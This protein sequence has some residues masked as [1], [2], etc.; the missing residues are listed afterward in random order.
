MI[1]YK[2]EHKY[3]INLGKCVG[4]FKLHY[5][6]NLDNNTKTIPCRL[7]VE[8]GNNVYDTGFIGDNSYDKELNDLGFTNVNSNQEIGYISVNKDQ[9]EPVIADVTLYTP[10]EESLSK[11]WLEC[12]ICIDAQEYPIIYGTNFLNE[13]G[14]NFG[15]LIFDNAGVPLPNTWVDMNTYSYITF[16]PHD[17][18]R[19]IENLWVLKGMGYYNSPFYYSYSLF[20]NWYFYG[21][22]IPGHVRGEL[23][24]GKINKTDC[25]PA[26]PPPLTIEETMISKLD[27]SSPNLSSVSSLVSNND[28][29]GAL[30]EWKKIT[31]NRLRTIKFGYFGPRPNHIDI[32]NPLWQAVAEFLV[33]RISAETYNQPNGLFLDIYGIAGDPDSDSDINWTAKLIDSAYENNEVNRIRSSY[34]QMYSLIVP[35]IY[36][37]WA[38]NDEIYGKKFRNILVDFCSNQKKLMEAMPYS[39]RVNYYGYNASWVPPYGGFPLWQADRIE[40]IIKSL[41]VFAKK[42]EY[43]PPIDSGPGSLTT[44]WLNVLNSVDSTSD[45]LSFDLISYEDF[46]FIC[47]SLTQDHIIGVYNAYLNQGIFNQRVTGIGSLTL[48]LCLFPEVSFIPSSLKNDLESTFPNLLNNSIFNDGGFIESSFNYNVVTAIKLEDVFNTI[49]TSL[50]SF[51]QLAKNILENK[52]LLNTRMMESLRTPFLDLPIVGNNEPNPPTNIW[53]NETIRNNWFNL[54]NPNLNIYVYNPPRNIGVKNFTSIAFPYSGYYVQR[55]NWEWDSPYLFFI[56]SRPINAG[57]REMANSLSLELHAYGRQLLINGGPPPYSEIYVREDQ[58]SD[59]AK[60]NAYFDEKSTY[61]TNT[62]IVNDL[63][64]S[65]YLSSVPSSVYSTTIQSKWHNSDEFDYMEGNYTYGYGPFRGSANPTLYVDHT[66]KIIFLKNLDCW[67][68]VDVLKTPANLPNTS[69]ISRDYS[70]IWKFPP[71]GQGESGV[72]PFGYGFSEGQV[73]SNSGGVYTSDPSGPNLSIYQFSNIKNFSYTKYYG[74]KNLSTGSA[75]RGWAARYLGDAIPAVDMYANW[76][77]SGDFIIA[78]LLIPTQ[79]NSVPNFTIVRGDIANGNIPNDFRY[80]APIPPTLP[81]PPNGFPAIL[82][83]CEFID[84][85][86][87]FDGTGAGINFRFIYTGSNY[88]WVDNYAGASIAYDESDNLWKISIQNII[89]YYSTQLYGQWYTYAGGLVPGLSEGDLSN[90]TV[91]TASCRSQTKLSFKIIY[92]SKTIEFSS[93]VSKEEHTC[94]GISGECEMLLTIEQSTG[95]TGMAL[96]STLLRINQNEISGTNGDI[97]FNFTSNNIEKTKD[98]SNPSS[99][100]W[101]EDS[102]GIKPNYS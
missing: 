74:E 3:T 32:A 80:Y 5:N 23:S 55:K 25:T 67:I 90:G 27:L 96:N 42:Q 46:I 89:T 6:F 81:T 87:S 75:Y 33:G 37:Y 77:G 8:W 29:S 22:N 98:I 62:I 28:Y 38:E 76:S 39:E 92:N 11:T 102:D 86:T 94:G 83:A 72:G 53:A 58:R 45:P 48:I 60:I 19:G 84:L 61:K 34:G 31:F 91:S 44:P 78:S 16:E 51:N 70:Q 17:I 59:F 54:K 43:T 7:K 68:I 1:E 64:Q 82:Y 35:I 97:E 95:N 66:R 79:Q 40:F 14:D 88:V 52:L 69:V 100:N 9:Q 49:D 20:G 13:H 71:Y 57:G 41:A 65:K 26:E 93:S 73:N 15:C 24:S 36:K 2:N 30:E 10:I 4:L 18:G 99:F 56:N 50:I 101:T 21:E 85:D 12:P 63:S 47:L